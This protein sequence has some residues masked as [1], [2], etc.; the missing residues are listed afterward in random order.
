MS[1]QK[2]KMLESITELRMHC[3]E[4]YNQIYVNGKGV[5]KR[6]KNHVAPIEVLTYI[7]TLKDK[8]DDLYE[9]IQGLE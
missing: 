4:E 8:V 6:G 3:H 1:E 2:D 7:K 9:A 5:F